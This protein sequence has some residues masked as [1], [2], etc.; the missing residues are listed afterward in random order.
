VL[1]LA[2]LGP[3]LGVPATVVAL[4][5]SP[6]ATELPEIMNAIIWIK[7]DKQRLALGNISG[8]MMIQATVPTALG[9]FFTPWIFDSALALAGIVTAL[10]TAGLLVLLRRGAL[11]PFGMS[12]FILFYS[13]FAGGIFVLWRS[14]HLA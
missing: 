7:Q 8:A 4:L 6:I 3:W 12:L 11:T 5:V 10:A 1:Q 14:A 9:L 13:A 2:V